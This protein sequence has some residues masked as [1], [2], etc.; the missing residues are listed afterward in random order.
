M[1]LYN[2]QS[3][4]VEEFVPDSDASRLGDDL[5][6]IE[7]GIV[8]SLGVL[9]I[10]AAIENELGV[11]IEPELLQAENY[12]TPAIIEDLIRKVAANGT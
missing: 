3:E 8:D 10:V 11:S 9:K 2:T 12:R 5:D 1:R 6:L 4:L 7:T